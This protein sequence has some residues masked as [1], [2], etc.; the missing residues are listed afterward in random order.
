[1]IFSLQHSFNLLLLLYTAYQLDFVRLFGDFYILPSQPELQNK[2]KNLFRGN[3]K[4]V[5]WSL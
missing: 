3:H 4:V 5:F 1:L 2:A